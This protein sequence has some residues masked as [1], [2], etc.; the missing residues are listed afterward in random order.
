MQPP[1]SGRRAEAQRNDAV[2]LEAAREVFIA[3]PRAPVSAVAAAAGVG[4]SALYKRYPSKEELLRTLCHD[5]L[6]TYT[7]E[8]QAASRI[9]DGFDGLRTFLARIVDEDVHALTV[10]LA[11]TFTPTDEMYADSVRAAELTAELFAR[12]QATGRMRADVVLEDTTFLLEGAAAIRPPD[13]QRAA[14]LR[15]RYTALFI[16]ALQTTAAEPLPGPPPTAAEINWRW[17]AGTSEPPD[18]R[19][20]G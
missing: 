7:R 12:A 14:A 15:R 3:D 13:P 16:D 4:I 11:G 2:I 18:R 19:R 10:H 5:G 20:S 6:R 9:P 17:A 1:Q 8:V